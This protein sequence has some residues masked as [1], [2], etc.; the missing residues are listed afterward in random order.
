MSGLVPKVEIKS[1]MGG[2]SMSGLVPKIGWMEIQWVIYICIRVD[3]AYLASL[4][5]YFGFIIIFPHTIALS[6]DIYTCIMCISWFYGKFY[7][8]KYIE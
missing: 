4:Y 6:D 3:F 2:N 7:S 1:R 5:Y 8:L